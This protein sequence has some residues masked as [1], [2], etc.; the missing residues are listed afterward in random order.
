MR[1]RTDGAQ[2]NLLEYRL[3]EGTVW[4]NAT[5]YA[6]SVPAEIVSGYGDLLEKPHNSTFHTPLPRMVS[7]PSLSPSLV[8]VSVREGEG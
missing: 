2:Y 6:V 5:E 8:Y 3:S 7:S 4:P 1:E